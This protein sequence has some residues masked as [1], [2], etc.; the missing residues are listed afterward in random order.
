ME[1]TIKE[2]AERIQGLRLLLDITPVEMA[3]S[4]GVSL[5]NYLKLEN[6]ELDFT[7][8]FIY[9]CA[10]IFK[11][12][13]VDILKGSSPRLSSYSIT[14]RGDGL[15]IT[16]REGFSYLHMAPLFKN[17]LAEPFYVKAGYSADEQDAEIALNSHAGQ[18]INYVVKGQLKIR[19]EDNYEILSEGDLIY[20]DSGK[21][22]GMIATGGQDCEFMAIILKG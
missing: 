16:R 6:G 1:K 15:P 22:H 10:E 19:I 9:K 20:Y 13:M 11:V 12:D 8:T 21:G 4:T 18:E 3:N 14:R 17:K 7:F 5:E 2:I